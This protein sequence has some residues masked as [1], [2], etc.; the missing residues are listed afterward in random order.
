MRFARGKRSSRSRIRW[1]YGTSDQILGMKPTSFMAGGKDEEI[2]F[3]VGQTTL[4]AIL[5]GQSKRG[6]CAILLGDD[7]PF[8]AV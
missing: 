4:G 2:R 8:L 3:A 1:F 5:I 7:T 6:I